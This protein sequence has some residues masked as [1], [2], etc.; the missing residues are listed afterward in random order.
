MD[1]RNFLQ[2]GTTALFSGAAM[3]G[4]AANADSPLQAGRGKAKHCILVYLLGGPSHLDMWD[5]KP[6]APSEFR[7]PFDPISTRTVGIRLSEHL[8]KLSEQTE[9][10]SIIRSLG[11]NNG[12]HPFMTYYTLTGRVSKQPLGANTILPP[13]RED[14][15]HMGCVIS[16]FKHQ[17]PHIPGY[18]AIPEVQV[19]MTMTPIAGGGRAGFLGPEYNPLAINGDPREK[20]AVAALSMPEGADTGRRSGRRLLLAMLDGFGGG[21]NKLKDYE[22]VRRRA[23]DL[24]DSVDGEGLFSLESEKPKLRDQYGRHRFGQSL[25]LARR[26]IERGVSFVGVHFNNMTKC[27]GWDTHKDN[28]NCLRN[29]LLPMVDQGLSSL[30]SD[31]SDRGL[32]DETLVVCM[33]EFGRTPRINK[34]AGRD[35]WGQCGSAVLAGGGVQGGNVVG[36]SNANGAYPIET[37]VG[38]PDMVATIYHA[39]GL[40][41]NA[42][43]VD[44]RLNRTLQLGD[45]EVIPG[46]F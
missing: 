18:V 7:G 31:L 21:L 4:R 43:V 29:E 40:N 10:L 42:V 33:G 17:L 26:L 23:L 39:L 28:F 6:D 34:N 36:A 13:S 1:R 32:L 9:R 14:D 24:T 20:D 16:K 12:D 2:A 11:Y 5:L 38:P 45:G 35:H 46:V 22:S 41:P 8:P 25:L 30:L 44:P 19:R 15:P 37:P 27:D 3:C